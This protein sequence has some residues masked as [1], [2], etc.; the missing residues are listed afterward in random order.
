M[1]HGNLCLSTGAQT[2]IP[3][4]YS[5]DCLYLDVYAPSLNNPNLTEA[6]WPVYIYIQGGGLNAL[7]NPNMNAVPFINSSGNNFVVVTFNYRVGLYGF[8]ASK[9]V[10]AN[11]D[12]NVGL[13]DQRE[14]FKWVQSNIH[15]V[16]P[17]KIQT[18]SSPFSRSADTKSSL[19]AIQDTL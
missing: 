19:A 5:E 16:K 9:E 4:G 6:G 2:S 11:G 18:S 3:S 13:L 7:A 15:L 1:Q 14:V 8:L 17:P 12:V 10:V